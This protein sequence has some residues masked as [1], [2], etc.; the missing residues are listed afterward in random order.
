MWDFAAKIFSMKSTSF[1]RLVTN[2]IRMV[3]P[4]AYPTYVER[5]AEKFKMSRIFA[6][7]SQFRVYGMARYATD[8]TFQQS[9]RRPG[10]HEEAQG[11]FSGKHK[12]YGYKTEVRVLPNGLALGA[13]RHDMGSISDVDIFYENMGWHKAELRKSPEERNV[14]DVSPLIEHFPRYWAVLMDKGYKGAAR[15]VRA[16]VAVKR[17]KG[18]D[19]ARA[20]VNT[21]RKFSSDQ[22]IVENFFGRQCTLCVLMA[23]KWRWAESN[24]NI[25]F[26]FTMTITNAHVLRHPLRD[27][28]GSKRRQIIDRRCHIMESTSVKRHRVQERYSARRRA[29]IEQRLPSRSFVQGAGAMTVEEAQ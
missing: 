25:F 18:R 17:P 16:L 4:F 26:Q 20:E 6:D 9:N 23:N 7:Q 21:N 19:L 15:E 2:F 28:D 27:E 22:I 12:V 24:Y 14:T 10:N 1:E 8:V 29:R 5:A 13:S 3:T 11:Y